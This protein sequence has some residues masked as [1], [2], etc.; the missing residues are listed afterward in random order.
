MKVSL[1]ITV[2]LLVLLSCYQVNAQSG[3]NV[4][5][6]REL[7]SIYKTDQY[8][9]ALIGYKRDP[10]KA[11][12][13]AA[14]YKIKREDLGDY[15]WRLQTA[16]DSAN[17]IR[18]LEIIAQYGYPGKSLVGSPANEATWI[19]IQHAP[20]SVIRKYF[21]QIKVA[22][23]KGE[24]PFRLAAMMEDRLLMYEGKEQIY[25]TQATG[26]SS[27]SGWTYFIWPIRDAAGVNERRRKAGFPE[28]VEENAQR[29]NITYQV[30]TLEEARKLRGR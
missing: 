15:L 28:T 6:Q 13:L 26:Y 7:D 12:S 24:L 5:L 29:M 20:D 18:I 2:I 14:V 19:V 4:P 16:S 10:A 22:G 1:S 17:L 11:D 21:P 3:I 8:Y 27:K 30:L 9:R 25:G 23:E